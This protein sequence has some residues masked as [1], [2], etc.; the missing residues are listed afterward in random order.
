MKENEIDRILADMLSGEELSG[1]DL[2]LLEEWKQLSGM[3]LRFEDT[4]R[5]LRDSGMELKHR[6]NRAIVF[7]R[8]E[9]KVRKERRVRLFKRWS[10]AAGVAL[11]FGIGGYFLFLPEKQ[12]MK[13]VQMV[14]GV[15]PG[16]PRAELVLPRGKVIALDSNAKDVFVAGDAMKVTTREN[17]LMYDSDESTGQEEYH[18]I[19]IPRGAEY[20]LLLSDNTKV[21]LN[22]GSSLRYPVRFRGDKREVF[23]E[24]EGYFEVTKDSTAPF[25]VKTGEVDVRVLGTSFNVSAYPEGKVV[26]ATLVEGKVSVDYKAKT[27]TLSPGMQLVYDRARGDSEVR[28]VDTEVYT[29][30]KD[31]YY[32]FKRESL[33]HIMDMLS[34]WYDVN[35]FYLNDDLKDMEFGGRLKRYEDIAYLLKRMEETQDI[36]FF[37]SDNTITVKK[38]TD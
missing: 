30:W 4:V 3:H 28:E 10:V 29:S 15:V 22:A 20:K 23:L 2:K 31:G 13:P 8:V 16:H 9:R 35:V 18:T 12:V 27:R 7:E 21:F 19:R 17:T 32:Y 36:E 37:I 34:R 33:E 24:G 5:E 11:M 6:E 26:E 1:E 25:I 38:K 14:S